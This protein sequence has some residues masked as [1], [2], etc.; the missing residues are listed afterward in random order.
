MQQKNTHSLSEITTFEIKSAALIKK[1]I[2]CENEEKRFQ[3]LIELG[4]NLPPFPS[5]QKIEENLVQGCQSKLYLH[6]ECTKGKFLFFAEAD[7]LISAGL[8]AIL[9]HVYH[10]E[11]LETLLKHAPN[12]LQELGIH[13]SLSPNRSV[14]F[15]HIYLKMKQLALKYTFSK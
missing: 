10:E 15:S 1:F 2:S 12:F 4:K 13:T 5:A 7:A 8:V 6:A 14:G 11:N 9:I 3:L